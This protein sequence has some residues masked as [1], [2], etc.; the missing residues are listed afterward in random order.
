ML[1]SEM[2]GNEK[3]KHIIN[4]FIKYGKTVILH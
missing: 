3:N 2:L 4:I 1:R